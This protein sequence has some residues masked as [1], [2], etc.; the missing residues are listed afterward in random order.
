MTHSLVKIVSRVSLEQ[1]A[2]II[3]CIHF[4]PASIFGYQITYFKNLSGTSLPN[5]LRHQRNT[6]ETYPQRAIR[7]VVRHDRNP[8]H[9]PSSWKLGRRLLPLRA[10][11]FIRK[12]FPVPK[13][14]CQALHRQQQ[15]S[16]SSKNED[17]RIIRER[18]VAAA[19]HR[20]RQAEVLLQAVSEH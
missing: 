9:V 5:R 15:S 1:R 6:G 10:F 7:D 14:P 19:G 17:G 20:Q 18:R 3:F 16:R 4:G 8:S 2:K 13:C 11:G 12:R